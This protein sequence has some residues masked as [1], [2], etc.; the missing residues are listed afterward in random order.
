MPK[1]GIGGHQSPKMMGNFKNIEY[2]GGGL[3]FNHYNNHNND[4]T[5][6]I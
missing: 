5:I 3:Q 6:N 2:S 1:K 4:T